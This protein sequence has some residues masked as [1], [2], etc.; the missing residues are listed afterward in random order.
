LTYSL[1]AALGAHDD[2]ELRRFERGKRMLSQRVP[3][4]KVL[5][6]PEDRPQGLRC[7]PGS[8]RAAEKV[9]VDAIAFEGGVQPLGPQLVAMAVAQE[10]AILKRGG[11]AHTRSSLCKTRPDDLSAQLAKNPFC[12]GH[13][14]SLI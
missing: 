12:S 3:G 13:E 10:G 9:F 7:R 2:Q 11:L 8:C 1:C 4:R 6:I 5:A 14:Q